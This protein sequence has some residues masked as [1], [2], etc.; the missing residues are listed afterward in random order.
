MEEAG[1]VLDI[2]TFIPMVLSKQEEENRP[3]RRVRRMVFLG[4]H[5][6]LPPVVKNTALQKYGHLDQSLFTRLVRLGVPT[7]KQSSYFSSFSYFFSTYL[8]ISKPCH[9]GARLSRT[10]KAFHL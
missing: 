10:C 9:S 6:Q 5:N 7:S 8:R 1:Q 3:A 4:D 2:E